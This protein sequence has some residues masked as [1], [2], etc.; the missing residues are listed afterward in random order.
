MDNK[1][2][3]NALAKSLGRD[4]KDISALIEGLAATMR[5]NLADMNTIALPGFGEFEPVKEDER[6]ITDLSTGKEMLMPP[7]ITVKFNPSAILRRKISER[8]E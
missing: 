5:D 6:I 2:A 7:N 8:H 1:A 4:S 3:V